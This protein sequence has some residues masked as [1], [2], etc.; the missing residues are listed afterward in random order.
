[1]LLF[2]LAL[3][4]ALAIASIGSLRVHRDRTSVPAR[5][6]LAIGLVCLL[7]LP[8]LLQRADDWHIV[9][10]GTLGIALLPSIH[11]PSTTNPTKLRWAPSIVVAALCVVCAER[12]FVDDLAILFHL[13]PAPVDV[14]HAGRHFPLADPT[15]AADVNA[16][17]DDLDR[18]ARPG[19]KVFVGPEDLRRTNLNDTFVYALLPDLRPASYFTAMVPGLDTEQLAR[20][21]DAADILLLTNRYDTW[22]EPNASSDFGSTAANEIVQR[23]FCP[24]ATHGGYTLLVRCER[25][26]S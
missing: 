21:I 13:R 4:S 23:L 16:T 12:P 3:G 8:Q 26:K 6:D 2:V 1:L 17:L 24:V 7:V 22:T 11:S 9:Y 15:H 10:A 18:F 14:S 19:D 25:T 5:L 20:E